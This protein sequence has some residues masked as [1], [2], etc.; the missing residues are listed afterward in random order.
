MG[1]RKENIFADLEN[2]TEKNQITDLLEPDESILWESS[3]KKSA[4][5]LSSI[6]RMLPFALIWLIFDGA[7]IYIIIHFA[8]S[9]GKYIY[10][11]LGFF[12]IHLTPV[13]IWIYNIIKA[14]LEHKNIQYAITDKKIIIRKGV[15][16]IDFKTIY[17]HEI[18]GVRC[19]VGLIDKLL[20]VGDI[21][22][23]STMDS[24]I[25]NDIQLPYE[26]TSRINQIIVDIQ[27][28]MKYPNALRPEKNEGYHTKY[29][30]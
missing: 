9:L 7:F 11:L 10:L 17:Y 25:L 27:T 19:R 30:G 21:Y 6:L 23:R 22:I 29:K 18:T 16:G 2:H 13:W 12:I 15:I 24:V 20:K 28:D 4:Y 3:P 8:Q 1:K 14:S 5:L 26:V